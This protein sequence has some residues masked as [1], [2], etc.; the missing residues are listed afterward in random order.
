MEVSVP[1]GARGPSTWLRTGGA[2]V[3]SRESAFESLRRRKWMSGMVLRAE[4]S[5]IA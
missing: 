4:K 5:K 1:D 2:L 3:Q